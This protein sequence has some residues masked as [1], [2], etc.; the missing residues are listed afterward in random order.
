MEPRAVGSEQLVAQ[1]VADTGLD[2]LGSPHLHEVLDAW[3]ADLS[4]DRFS[5]AGR[6]FLARQAA[7]N[8]AMRLRVR[9]A[10]RANPEIED[11]RLPPIIRIMG[12][13]RSGT[14]LLHQLMSL[15]PGVRSVRRWELVQPL[16]P[17]E[18]S[19]YAT[20]PRIARVQQSVEVLRGTDLER[21]HW[22]EAEDPEECTWGFLDASG[23]MGRGLLGVMP[24]WGDLVIDR[25]R[26]RRE[27][28]REY[29]QLLQLLLWRNPVPPG[30]VLVLKCPTDN[31]QVG[32]F[33]EV[34]PEAK[35]LLCHRDPFRTLVSSCR[36]QEIVG[37][38]HLASPDAAGI[39]ARNGRALR[40][41]ARFAEALVDAAAAA[42][43]RVASLQYAD[44]MAAPADEVLAA[45]GRLGV[46]VEPKQ[47]RRAVTAFLD[48]Q[49]H[50]RRAAPPPGYADFGHSPE[51]VRADPAI[52]AYVAAFDVPVEETR[53]TA[54]R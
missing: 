26:P 29:R 3:C 39:G 18:A 54:P 49:A 44:L 38:P 23:L 12:F 5:E 7:R 17:P 1:A 42:P 9:A 50:G 43:H 16:P 20:D 4:S 36:L 2:D 8:V 21:M 24:E 28:Y 6:Q 37:G 35:V 11:V 30:G 25:T 45:F 13:P 53:I 15:R 31:D 41:Q 14:T 32:T 46:S 40:V 33:L 22:V 47:M 34:F 27:T 19:T 10:L 48:A 51:Q 52:A